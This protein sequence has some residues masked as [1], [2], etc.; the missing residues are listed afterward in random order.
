[1]DK[2]RLR[3]DFNEMLEED[4]VLLSTTNERK[5]SE[6]NIIKL[7]EGKVVSLYE[8]NKYDDGESEYLLAEGVVVPNL[9]QKNPVVIWCCRI[10]KEGI[11]V[12]SNK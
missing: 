5:D 8:F 6:G 12:D 2:P 7:S 1:M 4:L 10:N 3:V 9:I 11:V